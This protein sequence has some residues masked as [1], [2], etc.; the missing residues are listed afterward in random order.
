MTRGGEGGLPH[1]RTTLLSSR[2]M[3]DRLID[4]MTGVHAGGCRYRNGFMILGEI[5]KAARS[6]NEQ[7]FWE[8]S[9]QTWC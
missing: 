5:E 4:V 8:D 3:I 7:K 9:T 2:A 1:A 6:T